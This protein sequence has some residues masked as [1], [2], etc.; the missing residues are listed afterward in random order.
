[1]IYQR[2]LKPIL[3][4]LQ[5]L[6]VKNGST[7][8]CIFVF[9]LKAFLNTYINNEI[10]IINTVLLHNLPM[11]TDKDKLI[12]RITKALDSIR[13]HLEADG[14]DIEVVDVTD[15]MR[16]Q[17]KWVGNCETCNMSAMTMKA[18]IESTIKSA[19]PEIV[20]VDALNG[21]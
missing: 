5:G 10:D 16:V 9:Q 15:D 17:V 11:I 1:V 12:D 6:K 18:G 3:K 2:H 21:L 13:P 14:G 4:Q 8:F 7:I 20:G 19:I